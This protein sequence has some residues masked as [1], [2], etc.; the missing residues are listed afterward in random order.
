MKCIQS[1]LWAAEVQKYVNLQ[2]I[3]FVTEAK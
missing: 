1:R 2:K 3:C